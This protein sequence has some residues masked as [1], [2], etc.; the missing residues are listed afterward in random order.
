MRI[1]DKANKIFVSFSEKNLIQFSVKFSKPE[2][3]NYSN[4]QRSKNA[5]SF[6]ISDLGTKTDFCQFTKNNILTNNFIYLILVWNF[7]RDRRKQ[8]NKLNQIHF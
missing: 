7:L 8:R 2:I 5:F 3:T 1:F 4:D 6:D